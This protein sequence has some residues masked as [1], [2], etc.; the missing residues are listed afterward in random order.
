M[1]FPSQQRPVTWLDILAFGITIGR[2]PTFILETPAFTY[3]C[4]QGIGFR[5]L[6]NNQRRLSVFKMC[7]VPTE[8]LT[9]RGVQR[10]GPVPTDSDVDGFYN[11]CMRYIQCKEE[12]D[13][14]DELIPLWN[15]L[16]TKQ[17]EFEIIEIIK[18]QDCPVDKRTGLLGYDVTSLGGW[19]SLCLVENSPISVHGPNAAG[20]R[21]GLG[22]RLRS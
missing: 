7:R 22:V 13:S 19:N 4:H 3:Q 17:A 2:F 18:E 16:G 1:G 8:G 11:L 9:Y 6:R 20:R 12:V 14:L 21:P 5:I 15:A 10:L